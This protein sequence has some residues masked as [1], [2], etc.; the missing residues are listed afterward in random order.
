[1]RVH[2]A[3]DHAGFELKSHLAE[4][5]TDQGYEVVDHGAHAFDAEDDYPPFCVAAAVAAVGEPGSLAI[6][7]GQQGQRCPGCVGVEHRDGRAGAS[8]Q[9]R[10]D[11]VDRRAHAHCQGGYSDR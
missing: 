9:R 1:M 4:W 11:R 10:P 3:A 2:I 5:L 8:A 6:V 7:I